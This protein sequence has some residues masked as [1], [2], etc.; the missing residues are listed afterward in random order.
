M[1]SHTPINSAVYS[2]EGQVELKHRS[3]DAILSAFLRSGRGCLGSSEGLCM[4]YAVCSEHFIS[5]HEVGSEVGSEV[6]G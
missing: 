4:L 5:V 1:R 2:A 3:L 6:E